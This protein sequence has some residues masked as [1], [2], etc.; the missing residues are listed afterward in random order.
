M[1]T[2]LVDIGEDEGQEARLQAAFDLARAFEGHLVAVQA[3]PFATYAMG[4]LGY[5]FPVTELIAAVEAERAA[6]RRRV[7]P[8]FAAEGISWEWHSVDG[9]PA[10]AL[11]EAARL[12]DAIVMSA[13]PF[14]APV[15]RQRTGDVAIR[16]PAPVIA[17]P[18]GSRGFSAGGS[19]L[20]L[21][22]GSQ[23][24]ALALRQALPLLRLASEVAILTVEESAAT[25]PARAAAAY[26]SRQGVHAEVIERGSGGESIETVIR[27]VIHERRPAYL[28]QGAYGHSRLRETLFGGVTRGLLGDAP[29][30]IVLAH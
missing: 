18:P 3:T 21:W 10:D 14:A 28:V 6:L 2:I 12:A 24:A 16:A 15:G 20:I 11:V 5:A 29:V 23:E 25:L 4:D 26:L 9:E 1:K 13:G 7:E 27:A 8:L 30:P 22:N 19:A 17:V